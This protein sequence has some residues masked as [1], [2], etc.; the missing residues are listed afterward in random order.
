MQEPA[1]SS[2]APKEPAAPLSREGS[3]LHVCS[4]LS[5]SLTACPREVLAHGLARPPGLVAAHPAGL[6]F[7]FFYFFHK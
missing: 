6:P 7:L 5:V 3:Q 2:R 1:R 4:L